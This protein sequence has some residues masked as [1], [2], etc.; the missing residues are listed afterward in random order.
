VECAVTVN[1]EW[2]KVMLQNF[3]AK[4]LH[5]HDLS[6]VS[7][8]WGN[9]SHCTIKHGSFVPN[10]STVSFLAMETLTG[11]HAHLNFWQQI[12]SCGATCM[13]HVQPISLT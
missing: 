4:E 2:Y 6:V 3:L 13:R 12:F 1:T 5:C 7:T 9:C 11:L 8:K 10:V